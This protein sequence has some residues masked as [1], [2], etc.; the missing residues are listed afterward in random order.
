MNPRGHF[1]VWFIDGSTISLSSLDGI[2]SEKEAQTRAISV[3]IGE[4]RGHIVKL[5]YQEFD[6]AK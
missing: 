5:F 3:S 4:G 1:I 6:Y 2:N